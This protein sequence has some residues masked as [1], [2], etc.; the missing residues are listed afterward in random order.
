MD[1]ST[2][3][4]L[5]SGIII[6]YNGLVFALI[7][8][9]LAFTLDR[10]KAGRSFIKFFLAGSKAAGLAISLALASLL[11]EVF[12]LNL[13]TQGAAALLLGDIVLALCMLA[14]MLRYDTPEPY[15]KWKKQLR[16]EKE[17]TKGGT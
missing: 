16:A 17:K 14:I 3:L 2:A 13:L 6:N 12:G 9:I 8:I 10:F 7:L 11:I 15:Q 1:I 4:M 5:L